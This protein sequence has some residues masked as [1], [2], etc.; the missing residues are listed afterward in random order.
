MG[1]KCLAIDVGH[2]CMKYS[3]QK[4]CLVVHW[5]YFWDLLHFGIKQKYSYTIMYEWKSPLTHEL[6][7]TGLFNFPHLKVYFM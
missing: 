2:M 6:F 4:T 3:C 1:S 5:N 7:Y